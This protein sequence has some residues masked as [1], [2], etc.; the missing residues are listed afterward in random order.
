MSD[1]QATHTPGPWK[2]SQPDGDYHDVIR[3]YADSNDQRPVAICPQM[4]SAGI[5]V[6]CGMT[7]ETTEAAYNARLIAAAPDLLE[8]CDAPEWEHLWKVLNRYASGESQNQWSRVEPIAVLGELYQGLAIIYER[9][10]TAI[11]RAAK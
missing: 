6:I 2:A 5:S 3:I 4:N 7:N 9:N 10:K 11:S 1:I 8:A